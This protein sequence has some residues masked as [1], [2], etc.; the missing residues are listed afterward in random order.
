[1]HAP[2]EVHELVRALAPEHVAVLSLK[3]HDR[4]VG[5]LTVLRGEARGAFDE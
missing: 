3:G 1:M 4:V 2:G 5:L